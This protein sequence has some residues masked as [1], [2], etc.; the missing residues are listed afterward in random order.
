M[1]MKLPSLEGTVITIKYDQ[2][3]AKRCYKNSLKIKRRVFAVTT[4]PPREEGVTRAEIAREKRPP[5]EDVLD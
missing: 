4:Q 1:K 2:K 3:V 5:A